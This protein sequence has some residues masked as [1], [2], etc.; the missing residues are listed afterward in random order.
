MLVFND[1]DVRRL[2]SLPALIDAMQD[3][4]VALS[5]GKVVQPLRNVMSWPAT[6]DATGYLFCK[7]VVH[8][9]ALVTKLITLVDGNDRR[10]LPTLMATVVLMDASTGQPVAVMDGT[11]LTNLRTAAVSALAAR[12]LSPPSAGV[13]AMLGS[14]ALARTHALAMRAVRPVREI[15]VWS[16][17]PDK[18]AAC[19][20]EIGGIACDTA[21]A[22]VRGADIVCT[23]T[24][25]TEPVLQGRWLA[26]GAVVTAVG[27]PRPDWRELDDEAMRG[28]VIADSRESA[29]LESGDV[30]LSGARV[31]AEL[32]ELLA[33]TRSWPRGETVVFKSLGQ[34]VE[35]AAAARLV[36]AAALAEAGQ[37][38]AGPRPGDRP[39]ARSD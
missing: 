31:H 37:A 5:A 2:L 29:Q 24:N 10:G 26:K 17:N 36:Y 3:A 28:C 21:E 34:A 30:M 15:R 13:V 27:A 11:W 9:G 39:G 38:E 32:G 35:D 12:L 19:A 33:G 4:L 23:V 8:D 25:A 7:P 1:A 22:A 6:P 18:V 14:G 20:A 16:R